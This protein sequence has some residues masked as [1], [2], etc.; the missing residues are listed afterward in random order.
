MGM[1]PQLT[2]RHT[3][4]ALSSITSIKCGLMNLTHIHM[5]TLV[6]I[7]FSMVS[8][9]IWDAHTSGYHESRK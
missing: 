3:R 9:P 5:D 1:S 4:S 8:I 7:H 2:S 6:G